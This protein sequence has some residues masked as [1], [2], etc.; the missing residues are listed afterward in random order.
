[1]ELS[2]TLF[3]R[4][5]HTFKKLTFS[6]LSFRW[7]QKPTIDFTQHELENGDVVSSSCSIFVVVGDEVGGR[8]PAGEGGVRSGS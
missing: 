1:L 6:F 7:E 4:N 3:W 5:H 8:V 2:S